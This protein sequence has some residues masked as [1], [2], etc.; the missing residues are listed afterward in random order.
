MCVNVVKLTSSNFRLW[1]PYACSTVYASSVYQLNT[2]GIMAYWI[3][4]IMELI[5]VVLHITLA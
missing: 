2:I 5:E 1:Q 4:L 3:E